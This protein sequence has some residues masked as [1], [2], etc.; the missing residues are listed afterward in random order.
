MLH[1][2]FEIERL[3]DHNAA[4]GK[5]TW[6]IDFAGFG[7][8][9]A[10][11][12][13]G[14]T[15]LPMF[16]NHYPE[17][18]GQI[19]LVD[20]PALF[21]GVWIGVQPILDLVTRS[22]VVFLRGATAF[23]AYADVQWRGPLPNEL[24]MNQDP[25]AAAAA[26]TVTTRRAEA[27]EEEQKW[28]QQGD[29]TS[30]SGSG[31]TTTA[32]SLTSHRRQHTASS[33]G[34]GGGPWTGDLPMH[35]WIEAMKKLPGKPGSFPSDEPAGGGG[36]GDHGSSNGGGGGCDGSGQV[37]CWDLCDH[38]TVETFKRCRDSRL[39]PSR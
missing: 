39:K 33:G 5:M 1:M 14:A 23:K 6:I 13:L 16:A 38:A 10:D 22:K 7:L 4:P 31:G 12:R 8:A 25:A 34:S 18:M 24:V 27:E 17:R 32:V 20:P 26:M 19:V 30:G 37:S 3:F 28:P 35:A 15:A 36:G 29:A 11:P 9:H 2:A 21:H